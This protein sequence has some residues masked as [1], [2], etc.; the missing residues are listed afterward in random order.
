MEKIYHINK[1]ITQVERELQHKFLCNEGS[2]SALGAK[3]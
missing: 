3:P 2:G 1:Y